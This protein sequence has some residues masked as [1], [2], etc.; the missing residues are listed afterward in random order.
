MARER[1]NY[2]QCYACKNM[3]EKVEGCNHMTC[4]CGAQFCMR[5]GDKW[6]TKS[7]YEGCDLIDDRPPNPPPEFAPEQMRGD[8]VDEEALDRM[9]GAHGDGFGERAADMRG[10]FL[11]EDDAHDRNHHPVTQW[12]AQFLVDSHANDS[13]AP[14]RLTEDEGED[15]MLARAMRASLLQEEIGQQKGS[16][17]V[18]QEWENEDELEIMSA[19]DTRR[20]A[21]TT[22]WE[23]DD[24]LD[25]A[26]SAFVKIGRRAA[27][28]EEEELQWALQE[29]LQFAG[30][31]HRRPR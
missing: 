29:S 27:A 4:V 22:E 6:R 12:M 10:P 18:D 5:C 20:H 30:T 16:Q 28:R 14:N 26:Q 21:P 19:G 25:E 9:F 7:C 2:Q 3:V 17:R 31:P 13:H 11:P 23:S 1:D 8:Y 24:L 15:E